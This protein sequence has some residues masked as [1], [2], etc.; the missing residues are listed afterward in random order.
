MSFRKILVGTD[1]SQGSRRA[2][3]VALEI[4]RLSGASIRLIH[5]WE[6]FLYPRPLGDSFAPE[7]PILQGIEE[8]AKGALKE[9]IAA[10]GGKGIAVDGAL[11]MAP[12][13]EAVLAEAKRWGAD[14]IVVGTHGRGGIAR[15]F[16]GSVAERIIRAADVPVLTARTLT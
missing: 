1:F 6:P 14:L 3:E 13:G 9:E 10:L 7:P 11:T 15:L 4:A 16:L 12:P 5:G 8:A 2:A